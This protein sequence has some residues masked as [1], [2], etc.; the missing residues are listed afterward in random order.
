MTV[1]SFG[2]V[3][4]RGVSAAAAMVPGGSSCS[5]TADSRPDSC[6]NHTQVRLVNSIRG[7]QSLQGGCQLPSQLAKVC[8]RKAR[9]AAGLHF[10][11]GRFLDS[12]YR[13]Y[14]SPNGIEQQTYSGF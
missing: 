5:A 8:G 4:G 1:S 13:H 6:K 11:G 12:P 10:Q 3:P 9:G 14:S 2:Y 7:R